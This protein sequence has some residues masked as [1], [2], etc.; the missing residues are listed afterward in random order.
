M[1]QPENG[2]MGQ[3][4]FDPCRPRQLVD[5]FPGGFQ[6]GFPDYYKYI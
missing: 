6:N 2:V 5:G 3:R 4:R 1:K